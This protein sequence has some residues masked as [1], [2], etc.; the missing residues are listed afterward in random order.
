[1]D[2]NVDVLNLEW[3]SY[4]SRD[5]TV[6]TL[7]CNYLRRLNL[8][9]VEGC[10]FNGLS[11]IQSLKPKL[12]FITNSVGAPENLLAVKFAKSHGV[13]V[14]TLI[15]EGT[16]QDDDENFLKAVIWGWNKEQVLFEDIHMQW[17]T[18]TRDLTNRLY[19]QN[20]EKVKVSGG[21]FFDCYKLEQLTSR[22]TFLTKWK[23]D[24]FK[25][26]IGVG[27]FD[28]GCV[29]NPVD[30]RYPFQMKYYGKEQMARFAKDRETFNSIII[31]TI[32]ENPSI[33][34]LLKQHPGALQGYEASA[35]EGLNEE[36]NVLIIKNE[37]SIIDCIASS[38]FWIV[39]ESTTA[40]EAW[41]LNRNTCLL[42]PSGRDFL[43]DIVNLGSP[44][45]KNSEELSNFIRIFY[46]YGCLPGFNERSDER[47]KIIKR[48]IQWDDGL[49]HVRVANQIIKL[50]NQNEHNKPKFKISLRHFYQ[51]NV[52]QLK[53]KY[54]RILFKLGL[55]IKSPITDWDKSELE[56]YVKK[57]KRSQELLYLTFEEKS[58][59]LSQING[60]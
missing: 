60:L 10:I 26:I 36:A 2:K 4:A 33:L 37:E 51:R 17:S 53:W 28:F 49:N 23:K 40:M 32:R 39:Y 35:I 48:I 47:Q 1:M 15:S 59:D 43:R 24:N 31:Q 54:F 52:Q 16:F 7:V 29:C 13:K 22:S 41:L 3:T 57:L 8:N 27:L 19:P 38:D 12:L 5:R 20:S 34:F 18:R 11:L 25:R 42:N 45:V 46:K 6:A 9:V 30:P 21:V 44:E 14:L 50:L 55:G 56:L 58:I